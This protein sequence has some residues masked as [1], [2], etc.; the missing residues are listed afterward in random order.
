MGPITSQQ[1]HKSRADTVSNPVASL[2]FRQHHTLSV[3]ICYHL[4]LPGDGLGPAVLQRNPIRDIVQAPLQMKA[5][6]SLSSRLAA[7][8]QGAQ[9][10]FPPGSAPSLP[11]RAIGTC[12]TSEETRGFRVSCSPPTGDFSPLFR[13][14]KGGRQYQTLKTFWGCLEGREADMERNL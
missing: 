2:S 14:D 9:Q 12:C 3:H 7:C 8:T 10:T 5:A 13:K 4:P 6:D 11:S 1:P